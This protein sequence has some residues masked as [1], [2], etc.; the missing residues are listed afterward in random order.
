[1]L[2]PRSVQRLR[3]PVVVLAV[4]GSLLVSGCQGAGSS[5]ERAADAVA[6]NTATP[7]PASPT[8]PATDLSVPQKPAG[9]DANSKEGLEAFTRY[10]FELFSYGY[11]SNDWTDFKAVTDGGCDTCT[12]VIGEVQKH[13]ETGGWIQ[14]GGITVHGVST[15]FQPG[16]NGAVSSFVEMEQAELVYFD[17]SGREAGVSEALPRTRNVAIAVHKNN[18][19]VMIDFGSPS[20]S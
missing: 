19:W 13:Y 3:L 9:V 15:K 16:A 1:M 10:W 14:G 17:Q 6:S 18:R 5:G 7:M 20:A 4:T 11:A 8:G 2:P 12:N